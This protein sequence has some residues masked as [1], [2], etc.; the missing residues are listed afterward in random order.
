MVSSINRGKLVQQTSHPATFGGPKEY[1]MKSTNRLRSIVIASSAMIVLVLTGM[2]CNGYKSAEP[3]AQ[4]PIPTY[5]ERS[6]RDKVVW[7]SPD[8]I[9][10]TALAAL[11]SAEREKIKLSAVPVLVPRDPKFLQSSTIFVMDDAAYSFGL[12]KYADG[13]SFDL[14][15][16][17]V[18][19]MSDAPLP[20]SF[21]QPNPNDVKI[22]QFQVSFSQNEND[23][24]SATWGSYGEVGYLMSLHCQ[25]RTDS[26]CLDTAYFTQLIKSLVFVGGN[27]IP[28]ETQIQK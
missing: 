7:P 10:Q 12:N 21:Y 13:I 26:R 23:N 9:D 17:R 11:P 2:R 24:W 15:G 19:T 6:V 5:T 4:P 3:P 22:G 14:M 16:N 28:Y 25:D 27:F 1:P 8:S 20:D 18:S